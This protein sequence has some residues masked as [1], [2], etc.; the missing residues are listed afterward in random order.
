[1]CLVLRLTLQKPIVCAILFVA[2]AARLLELRNPSQ[3]F[4]GSQ[5]DAA[6]VFDGIGGGTDMYRQYMGKG[7]VDWPATSAWVSFQQMQV[8]TT[9]FLS[10]CHGLAN[11]L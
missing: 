1:M 6:N 5:A 2:A 9:N 11:C 3:V 8:V 4:S 7:G 10:K